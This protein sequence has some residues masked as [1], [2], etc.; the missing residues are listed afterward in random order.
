MKRSEF[1]KL[2]ADLVAEGR[3]KHHP[4]IRP[5]EAAV[6]RMSDNKTAVKLWMKHRRVFATYTMQQARTLLLGE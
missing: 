2:Y 4:D 1:I 5:S 6:S 3:K